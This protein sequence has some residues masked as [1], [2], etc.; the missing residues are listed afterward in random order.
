MQDERTDNDDDVVIVGFRASEELRR[1]ARH[2]ALDEGISLQE[3]LTR[4]LEKYL[5]ESKKSFRKKRRV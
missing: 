2:R 3:L 5:A 4:A 1:Q